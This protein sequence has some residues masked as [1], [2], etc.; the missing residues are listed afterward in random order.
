MMLAAPA[1]DAY[2]FMISCMVL[3]S[4]SLTYT[5]CSIIG[6]G[7]STALM[8]TAVSLGLLLLHTPAYQL[9]NWDPPFRS[10]KVVIVLFLLSNVFLVVVPLIPPTSTRLYD[11]L[12][13]WVSR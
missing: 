5:H 3:I 4:S 1:G 10:P 7:Y 11:H 13:Y 12:P 8:F 2:L 9:W 6:A